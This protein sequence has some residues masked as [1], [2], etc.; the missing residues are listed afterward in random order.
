MKTYSE[1]YQECQSN[2]DKKPVFNL[3]DFTL[4]VD[5][6]SK[7]NFFNL[8]KEYEN[9]IK[10]THD[11]FSYLV[12]D[13]NNLAIHRDP[14]IDFGIRLKNIK[15]F[16]EL[17]E[18]ADLLVPQI[19]NKL[20]GCNLFVEGV[21]CYRNVH[22]NANLRS[23][24]LWHYDNDPKEM[25]KALIYLNDV[26]EDSGP[27]SVLVDPNGTPKKIETS[28]IDYKKWMPAPNGS[29]IDINKMPKYKEQ[30]ILGEA[31]TICL[32]D[33]NI[34]HKANVCKPGKIRDVIVFYFKPTDRKV[35]V[36]LD[37]KYCQTWDCR[38]V[39]KNPEHKE[40]G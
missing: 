32:F 4:K 5:R 3:Y 25:T 39:N 18:L 29:R 15:D 27:F 34:I 12:S 36:Y 35:Q 21:Y 37:D 30:K 1:Y 13:V 38:H 26:D 31:G 11:R 10:R 19:E 7:N 6:P 9:L 20:Y 33:N 2:F 28:K 17:N 16:E 22:R 23:S 24:W 40:K 14:K 8:P